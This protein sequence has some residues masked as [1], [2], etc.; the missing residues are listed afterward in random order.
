MDFCIDSDS[1]GAVFDFFT[2]LVLI[3]ATMIWSA[4][5]CRRFAFLAQDVWQ[6]AWENSDH[7]ILF[8]TRPELT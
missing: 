2:G 5:T 7:S 8:F 3:H 4:A 6:S 1:F